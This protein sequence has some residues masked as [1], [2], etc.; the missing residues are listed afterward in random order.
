MTLKGGGGYGRPLL[1]A[2]LY[3]DTLNTIPN[4][5]VSETSL[6]LGGYGIGRS[7]GH[8]GCEPS[9]DTVFLPCI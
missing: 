9:Q 5:C 1:H 3:P 7:F 6:Y 2:W 4:K 8:F